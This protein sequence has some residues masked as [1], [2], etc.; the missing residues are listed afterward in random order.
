MACGK[1]MRAVIKNT[2]PWI[3]ENLFDES[4]RVKTLTER[5][6]YD[7]WHFQ[8]ILRQQTGYNF[9]TCI[10]LSFISRVARLKKH[11][12]ITPALFRKECGGARLLS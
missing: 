12:N 2:L 7:H 6:G 1:L 9:A 10:R 5:S 4:I 3:E 8:R 11:F